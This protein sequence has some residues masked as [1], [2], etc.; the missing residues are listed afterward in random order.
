MTLIQN[1]S[2][3]SEKSLEHSLNLRLRR[4]SAHGSSHNV[5]GLSSWKSGKAEGRSFPKKAAG[6]QSQK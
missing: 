4:V 2:V 3:K 1:G 5:A 6:K